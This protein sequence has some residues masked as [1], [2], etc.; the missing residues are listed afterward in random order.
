M[1][2]NVNKIQKWKGFSQKSRTASF[3]NKTLSPMLFN[4]GPGFK[5]KICTMSG[6]NKDVP[7]GL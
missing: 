2:D 4:F 3:K 7:G 5:L 1:T 6:K